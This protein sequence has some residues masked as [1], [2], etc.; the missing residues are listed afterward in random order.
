LLDLAA[1]GRLGDEEPLGRPREVFFFRHGQEIAQVTD[2][3][4]TPDLVRSNY[5]RIP[6]T[7]FGTFGSCLATTQEVAQ[8][9]QPES[10]YQDRSQSIAKLDLTGAGGRVAPQDFQHSSLIC[11]PER[12]AKAVMVLDRLTH[13]RLK[14]EEDLAILLS[15]ARQNQWNQGA[16][17]AKRID[18]WQESLRSDESKRNAQSLR[19]LT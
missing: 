6:L 16:V 15:I 10:Q 3:H 5:V 11:F 18:A 12:V 1:E 9:V 13:L 8:A 14:H 4:L 7:H 2:F 19:C 17:F